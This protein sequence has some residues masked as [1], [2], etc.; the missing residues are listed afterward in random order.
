[1]PIILSHTSALER[2]RSAPPSCEEAFPVEGRFDLSG[3]KPSKCELAHFD[4]KELGL[5]SSPIHILG[6]KRETQS[7]SQLLHVHRTSMPL[8]PG[9]L[10]RIIGPDQYASGPELAFLQMASM[11]SLLELIVL[12]FELCGSYSH[13]APFVSGFYERTP[14]TSVQRIKD[15]LDHLRGHHGIKRARK[16][17]DFVLDGCASPM[18]TVLACMLTL[19]N[20][21]GG[22]G[23][24]PPIPNKEVILDEIAR[25][26][27]GT[28]TCRVDLA[29]EDNRIGFEY[30]GGPFHTDEAKDRLRREA[31]SHEKWT[32]FTA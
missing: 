18:E 32:I 11:K 28:R 22:E 19:P 5:F 13:F 7:K 16:A 26:I 25:R 30:F 6:S 20:D 15:A 29:W 1:M 2:L 8:L 14:L 24:A 12:G 21:M 3:I 9:E 23:F 4:P 31:L 27:T 10:L 17:L